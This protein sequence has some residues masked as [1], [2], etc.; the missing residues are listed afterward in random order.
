M[1]AF[2]V[3]VVPGHQYVPGELVDYDKE[4]LLGQ[5]T[6]TVTG[7]LDSLGNVDPTAGTVQGQPFIFNTGSGKWGPGGLVARQFLEVMQG[8]T[9]AAAGKSGAAPQPAAGQQDFYLAGDAQWKAL[10]VS[11]GQVAADLF[12]VTRFV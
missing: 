2:V 5:P 8:C 3:V 7:T 11:T 10:P 12:L 6:I 9:P 4:N 1:G